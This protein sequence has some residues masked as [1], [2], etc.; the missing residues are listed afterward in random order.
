MTPKIRVKPIRCYCSKCHSLF[1][2]EMLENISITVFVKHIATIRCQDC[3][4]SYKKI[5]LVTSR[6]GEALIR[7]KHNLGDMPLEAIAF[8]DEAEKQNERH[9]FQ[10]AGVNAKAA[11]AGRPE[12]TGAEAAAAA[13]AIE[14]ALD[15]DRAKDVSKGRRGARRRVPSGVAKGRIPSDSG[16]GA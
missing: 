14:G 3:G 10:R 11:L 12:E 13:E 1:F 2:G 5:E 6:K 4:A 16:S 8:W 15:A 9:Q 7:E